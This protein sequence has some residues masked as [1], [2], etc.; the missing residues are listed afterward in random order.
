[1]GLIA[2][3]NISLKRLCAWAGDETVKALYP[4]SFYRRSGLFARGRYASTQA[5][6]LELTDE[7]LAARFLW[8]DDSPTH[9]EELWAAFNFVTG[10]FEDAGI[11][12]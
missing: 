2:Q 3:P 1:M 10:P 7:G 8:L 5:W 6:P 11:I 12:S 4:V 9:S